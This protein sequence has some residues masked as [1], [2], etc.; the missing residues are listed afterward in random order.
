MQKGL[1][2]GLQPLSLATKIVTTSLS[3]NIQID[4]N[5]KIT[6]ALA[7]QTTMAKT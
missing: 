1:L 5:S 6:K 7:C 4:T 3:L 2:T